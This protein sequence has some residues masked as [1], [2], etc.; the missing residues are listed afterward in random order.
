[1]G[2]FLKL[3]LYVYANDVCKMSVL[4]IVN[5]VHLSFNLYFNIRIDF[6]SFTIHLKS[7]FKCT[8]ANKVPSTSS[9]PN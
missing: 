3:H 6:N 7:N 4:R 8:C 1:M 9:D 5:K 2:F